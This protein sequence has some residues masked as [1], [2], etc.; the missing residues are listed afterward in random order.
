MKKGVICSSFY[1]WADGRYDRLPGL[2]VELVR[3]QVAVIAATGDDAATLAAKAATSAIPII[4]AGG[5]DP[6]SAG[7]VASLTR[8]TAAVES[9]VAQVG[10]TRSMPS[11]A[12][13][14]TGPPAAKLTQAWLAAAVLGV[15]AACGQVTHA[16]DRL[17]DEVQRVK[18]IDFTVADVDREASFFTKILQFEKIA[19]FRLVGGEWGKLQGVFNASMRIVHLRLGD[20]IVEL[21]QYV[22]PP[23]GRPIPVPSYS[24]DR[25]FQHMAIVVRD[26]D[27]AYKILQDN[28]VQQIS[29]YPITIPPSNPGAAGI[30][31][32]KFHDPE[33]HD[34]EL[35]YFPSGKGDASW[36]KPTDKLFLG[37]DHTAMTI[38]GTEAS[39]AF[40]RDLLGLKVGTV[41]L[42]TGITQEVLDGLFNDTCLVT[43]ML[44]P[45]APPHIEFLDYKTPPG[46]RPLPADTKANDLWHW[47]TTLV[48]KDIAALTERL[49]KAGAQF[50]TPE[51]V[52]IPQDA[53]AQLGFKRAMLVRDPTGHALRLV[54]E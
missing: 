36:H 21:T 53:Q 34:L 46:G 18:T 13:R 14:V 39:T 5:T 52:A 45:S 33:R 35:I 26:M 11:L 6:V 27:A 49:R 42:N 15:L 48:T 22:S 3:H 31:A 32:I 41:T 10:G 50:I 37:L 38:A 24:N 8:L 28:N 19:D 29:A 16:Q 43:A 44:P 1:R 2:A 30:K 4:F 51:A 12:R 20:Q 40:Y 17:S 9:L 47:Q 23:A 54:E 7:I 25:W